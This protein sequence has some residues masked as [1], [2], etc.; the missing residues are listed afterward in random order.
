MGVF[1]FGAPGG[2]RTPDLGLRKS[3][4]NVSCAPWGPM[5]GH[6]DA[7]YSLGCF[8]VFLRL[9]VAVGVVWG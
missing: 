8:L 1:P 5:E 7:I 9:G 4:E 6:G 2:I 3:L